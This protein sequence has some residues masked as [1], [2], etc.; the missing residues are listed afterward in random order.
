M[1]MKAAL[2]LL[3]VTLL[4]CSTATVEANTEVSVRTYF[5]HVDKYIQ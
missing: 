5:I 4:T 3:A 2:A 1:L